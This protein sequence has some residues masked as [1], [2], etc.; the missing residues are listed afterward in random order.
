MW[1]NGLLNSQEK[2]QQQQQQQYGG[3]S[4]LQRPRSGGEGSGPGR[5]GEG[6]PRDG[7]GDPTDSMTLDQIRTQAAMAKQKVSGGRW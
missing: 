1:I 5:A 7:D 6:M 3:Q 4:V 2:Q